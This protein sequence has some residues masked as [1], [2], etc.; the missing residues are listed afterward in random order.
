MET[1]LKQLQENLAFAED[2][3]RK[4]KAIPPFERGKT[5]GWWYNRCLNQ[6]RVAEKA[7]TAYRLQAAKIPG[8]LKAAGLPIRKTYTTAI[9]GWHDHS[10]GFWSHT[11]MDG[12]VWIYTQS[13]GHKALGSYKDVSNL[14]V[15]VAVGA[16]EAAGYTV[17]KLGKQL[18]ITDLC[19]PADLL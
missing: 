7:I 1:K 11:E 16:L 3:L 10:Y 12:E 9:K 19:T 8:I 4:H 17:E 6:V 14:Q 13:Q 2:A 18:K 15:W 5:Y